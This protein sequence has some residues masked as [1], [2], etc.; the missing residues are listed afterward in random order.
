MR[1][2]EKLIT[3]EI[4][5]NNA[6]VKQI[7]PKPI[8]TQMDW[9]EVTI[10][11]KFGINNRLTPMPPNSKEENKLKLFSDENRI[12]LEDSIRD[13]IYLPEM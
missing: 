13:K 10:F 3:D 11:N 8:T 4:C 5:K 12:A 9:L 1:E 7:T 2:T 6:V